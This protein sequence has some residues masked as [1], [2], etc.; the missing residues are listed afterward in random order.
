[1]RKLKNEKGMA[2]I[3]TLLF[4]VILYALSGIF[5][6]RV[7]NESNMARVERETTKSFYA[8]QAASQ[9]AV[10]QLNIL[11]NDF[12]TNTILNSDPSGVISYATG[13]VASGDGIG[14]LVFAVRDNNAPVLTPN[15]E[16]AEYTLT[17]DLLPSASTYTYKIIFTEK[18]DPSV[19]GDDA[20]DFPFNY[21]VEATGATGNFNNDVFVNGDFTVRVQR[22]NFA[23]YA[24]FTNSQTTPSG[25]NV[26]FTDKTNFAGPVHTND[27]FNFAWNPSGTFE[28]I[29]T[30]S[31]Q[32]ARFYNNGS[33]IL[34]DAALNGTKDVPTFNNEFTRGAE[35]VT[36]G[37]SAQESDMISQAKGSGTYASKGVYI[38]NSSGALTAGIYV[39]GDGTIS[40]SV[41]GSNNAVYTITQGSSTKVVTVN[42]TSAQTTVQDVSAGTTTT[43]S[44]MPDGAEDVGTIIYVDGNVT[45][46]GGTVQSDTQLTIS[47][48][49]DIVITNHVKY[50]DYTPATGTPGVAGYVPPTADGT[51]NMLG[52]VS[53]GG[54]VRIG[55]AAPNNIE[56]HGT[57]LAQDG[58]FTVDNYSSGSP[59]GT[60]TL[61]GGAFTDDY[62]A[63]GTFN[64]STGTQVSGYGRNF[65]YDDRM[66]NGQSPP[67][68]PTLDAFI[69]F[70]PDIMDKMIWQQG[71]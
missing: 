57:V 20:W 17:S 8:G 63:F 31:Q 12:L 69:A 52:L 53:W 58:I 43:Y 45:S 15:G 26:W 13:K 6:L 24:L 59:R 68:F 42:Q 54:S 2:L 51:N 14:W 18:E 30:Q 62:G 5:L 36:L 71:E 60:A 9:A 7:V 10:R 28:E 55:T 64:S 46:L 1:M 11:I 29:V 47:S 25:T 41:D 50:T 39:K 4:S 49:T 22:D 35:T 66:Q 16:Q 21:K 38:P 23:K 33:S 67:Y 56:I 37:T 44:G 32:T 70:S 19:S 27:R 34:L 40:M 3:L 48:K 61:L 65:V